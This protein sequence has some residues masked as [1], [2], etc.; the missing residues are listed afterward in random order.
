M[1]HEQRVDFHRAHR[2]REVETNGTEA[3][4]LRGH[5]QFVERYTVD[6]LEV[7]QDVFRCG[8]HGAGEQTNRNLGDARRGNCRQK[9]WQP[10]DVAQEYDTE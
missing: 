1:V 4:E 7:S 10:L 6:W 2:A 9:G 5:E 8:R 3:A